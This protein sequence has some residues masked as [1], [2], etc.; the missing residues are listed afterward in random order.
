[1]SI[2]KISISADLAIF[3]TDLQFYGDFDNTDSREFFMI[4]NLK[5]TNL[6]KQVLEIR[7]FLPTV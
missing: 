2:L 5:I 3:L 6:A 7:E 1:M 4:L